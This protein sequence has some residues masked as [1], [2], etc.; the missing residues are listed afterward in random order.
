MATSC[1][2]LPTLNSSLFLAECLESLHCTSCDSSAKI[3]ILILDGGSS[4]LTLCI[5]QEYADR[6]KR[7]QVIRAPSLHP[8]ERLN[9]L[10]SDNLY[11]H[12]MMCHS[13]DLYNAKARFAVLEELKDSSH[14]MRGSQVF[15]FQ[16]ALDSIAN[17]DKKLQVGQQT[18]HPLTHQEI[19]P[20]LLFWWCFSLN[21]L[22]IDVEKVLQNRI[23]F[24][25]EK[26]K[27]CA[28]WYFSWS[29]AKKGLVSNSQIITTLTRHNNRGD[30]PTNLINLEKE[31]SQIRSEILNQSGIKSILSSHETSALLS[32]NYSYGNVRPPYSKASIFR[33]LLQKLSKHESSQSISSPDY[34]DIFKSIARQS[35]SF[36]LATKRV[37]SF[38]ISR[39]R[40]LYK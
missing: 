25:H 20:Q 5:A 23:R 40:L 32:V 24:E 33:S 1:F 6:Y 36:H 7:V 11:T 21:T 3:P 8:A 2:V 38:A 4:D 14:L 12:I 30:G 26:Y 28:D 27:Y 17:L 18:S 16:S 15:Y 29:L 10:M 34:R 37:K 19:F 35:S 31:K 39:A 13:D 9:R 22:T